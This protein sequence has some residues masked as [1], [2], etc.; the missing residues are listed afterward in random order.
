VT[1][2]GLSSVFKQFNEKYTEEKL[3]QIKAYVNSIKNLQPVISTN[4]EFTVLTVN[5]NIEYYVV[6]SSD[7]W[8]DP[9]KELVLN[10]TVG[11][12]VVPNIKDGLLSVNFSNQ[13]HVLST[14]VIVDNLSVDKVSIDLSA[15]LF[16]DSLINTIRGNV[17]GIDLTK[18]L[19]EKNRLFFC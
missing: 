16:V 15:R 4:N 13:S 10:A 18:L 6:N 1:T 12:E 9:V 2:N 19:K 3:V 17:T 14:G 7:P 8:D 5:Y 11:I